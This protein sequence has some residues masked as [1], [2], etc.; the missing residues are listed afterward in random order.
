MFQIVTLKEKIFF[1]KNY[2][3]DLDKS[4]NFHINFISTRVQMKKLC[5]FEIMTLAGLGRD[6]RS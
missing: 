4:Y 1:K 6:G 5:I 2:K 3:L